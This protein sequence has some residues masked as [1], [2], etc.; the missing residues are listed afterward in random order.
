VTDE[1]ERVAALRRFVAE[2]P[3]GAS[4]RWFVGA[5]HGHLAQGGHGGPEPEV[6][7]VAWLVL[8]PGARPG[9]AERAALR[10]V[11]AGRRPLGSLAPLMAETLGVPPPRTALDPSPFVDEEP[12][13]VRARRRAVE[14]A[15]ERAAHD[16]GGGRR[17]RM[18]AFGVAATA[19]ASRLAS[20]ALAASLLP[21]LACAVGFVALGPGLTL[22][23][24]RTELAFIVRSVGVMALA[25]LASWPFAK[26]LG[27]HASLTLW[28]SALVPLGA[29]AWCRG[30]L[31]CSD[32]GPHEALLL[33]ATG[34]LPASLALGVMA[35]EAVRSVTA[36][37]P[38]RQ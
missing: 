34:L 3:D 19:V 14:E 21:V 25:A 24:I 33:P 8:G 15:R 35:I 29:L 28:I 11:P 16:A 13:P 6:C 37:R 10:P 4:V 38:L 27:A 17:L 30:S 32:V 2:Q 5:D 20:R 7:H 18:G 26:R 31:G 1:I 23:A 36:R 9:E 12:A 22:S